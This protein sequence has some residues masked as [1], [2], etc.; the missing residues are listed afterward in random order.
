MNL[1]NSLG[2]KTT[3][4]NTSKYAFG[5]SIGESVL[6]FFAGLTIDWFGRDAMFVDELVLG[7]FLLAL[8]FKA[9]SIGRSATGH[10]EP[11]EMALLKGQLN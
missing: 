4:T 1:P 8:Y 10:K 9:I 6:P 7:I 11:L 3:T 2:M 5:G